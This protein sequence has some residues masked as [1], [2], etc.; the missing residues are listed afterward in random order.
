MTGKNKN[1]AETCTEVNLLRS[2]KRCCSLLRMAD[3]HNVVP[4]PVSTRHS[5]VQLKMA[6]RTE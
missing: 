3:P 5:Q 6:L 4:L 1:S 2:Q